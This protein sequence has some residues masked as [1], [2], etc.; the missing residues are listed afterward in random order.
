MASGKY[1]ILIEKNTNFTLPIIV[2]DNASLPVDL[3]G[4]TP[5][6]H[7]RALPPNKD[8]LAQFTIANFVPLSG[9]FQVQLTSTETSTLKQTAAVYDVILSGSAEIVRLLD[10]NATIVQT[11]TRI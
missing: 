10:G 8:L 4:Y 6:A 9:S 3:T 2:Q 1:N 5:Y 7:L 11:V